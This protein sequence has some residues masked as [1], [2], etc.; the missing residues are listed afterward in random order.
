MI[1]VCEGTEVREKFFQ[2]E[3]NKFVFLT[4]WFGSKLEEYQG[5]KVVPETLHYV[6]PN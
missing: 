1:F 6:L 3:P 4:I 5:R 2:N